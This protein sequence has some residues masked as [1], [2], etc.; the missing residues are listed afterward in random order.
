MDSIPTRNMFKRRSIPE[1]MK[2]IWMEV[3]RM[4]EYVRK[5]S[6]HPEIIDFSRT[7]VLGCVPR[8]QR[9]EIQTIHDFVGHHAR[10]V[11]DPINR[12]TITTPLKFLD[13]IETKGRTTGDCDELSTLE[14]S[15]LAAIGIEPRFRFGGEGR[16][17][18]HVWVQAKLGNEWFDLEPS[19]YLDAGFHY[20]FPSYEVRKIFEG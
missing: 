9:C 4:V 19:G 14:A 5:F 13:D 6:G 2:G 20:E 10:F 7:L 11:Q 3:A 12:E 1:G 15:L 8:D 18:Y 17:M 16:E